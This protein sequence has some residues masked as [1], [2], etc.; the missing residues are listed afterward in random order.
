[1]FFDSVY[2]KRPS[3]TVAKYTVYL[4]ILLVERLFKWFWVLF[5]YFI[6]WLA[7]PGSKIHCILLFEIEYLLKSSFFIPS[8][9]HQA[10]NS[11]YLVVTTAKIPKIWKSTSS[12]VYF[13]IYQSQ[14]HSI[15]RQWIIQPKFI[16]C[17]SNT[18]FW[19]S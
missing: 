3:D 2:P 14:D 17:P 19:I 1:M 15:N 8:F 18:F 10:S 5:C 16:D 12:D 6:I 9:R 11:Y 4:L 7:K 13:L